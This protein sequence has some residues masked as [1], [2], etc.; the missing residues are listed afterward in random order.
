MDN[1]TLA[2]ALE[3]DK[4]ALIKSL[5]EALSSETEA[6][7]GIVLPREWMAREFLDSLL[8]ELKGRPTS[9]HTGAD[10]KPDPVIEARNLIRHQF[11]FQQALLH[12]L[13]KS[14]EITESNWPEIYFRLIKIFQ[15]MLRPQIHD[16]CAD[17]RAAL[18]QDM[19]RTEQ[20]LR[21]LKEVQK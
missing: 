2:R 12:H 21:N 10:S 5:S 14:P 16:S 20:I 1:G 8:L 19:R 18:N 7:E 13:R 6:L 11:R 17:C 4:A 9:H 3:R 15:E